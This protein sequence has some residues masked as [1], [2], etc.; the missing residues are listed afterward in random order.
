MLY[1]Y[2]YTQRLDH[3]LMKLLPLP[4]DFLDGFS[5]TAVVEARKS[6]ST[7][8]QLGMHLSQHERGNFQNLMAHA[9]RVKDLWQTMV[10]LRVYTIEL[11]DTLDLAWDVVLSA[12][13]VA[14]GR[15]A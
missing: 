6:R 1:E 2:M 9:S 7:I 14:S 4:M 5:H 11:W 3:V 12:L 15:R 10:T 8:Q 13:N